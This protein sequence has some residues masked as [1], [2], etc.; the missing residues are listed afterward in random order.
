MKRY[1]E[2]MHTSAPAARYPRSEKSE[3]H[4]TGPSWSTIRMFL[5]KTTLELGVL[6]LLCGGAATLLVQHP[7]FQITD[8]KIEGLDS[9]AY[10]IAQKS[11][12]E[13]QASSRA[14]VPANN[15]VLLQVSGLKKLLQDRIAL[16]SL[17][18]TKRFP[19]TLIVSAAERQTVF[20][21][22]AK[23]GV[24][25]VA[26]DGSLVRWYDGYT[27]AAEQSPQ[28]NF[29][30]VI[31]SAEIQS[32]K[33]L[34]S[35]IAAETVKI[36]T[37]IAHKAP[38]QLLGNIASMELTDAETLRV[39]FARGASLLLRMD[40][41]IDIQIQKG[42]LSAKKYPAAGQ[43]DVRFADKVFISF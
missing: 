29:I 33:L 38:T 26:S 1:R 5:N 10:A 17:R 3:R 13:I 15:Y 8:V 25:Y 30:K 43:I 35:V 18:V 39:Q 42:E 9:H 23:N 31:T 12:T 2:R 11:V 14:G 28:T 7:Y 20:I 27:Y 4:F 16:D 32:H 36:L 21:V 6:G 40:G 34:E 41:D 24:A 37:T 22:H 19:H